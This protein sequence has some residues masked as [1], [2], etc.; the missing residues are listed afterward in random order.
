MSSKDNGARSVTPL[1]N[2]YLHFSGKRLLGGNGKELP[3]SVQL[4]PSDRTMQAKQISYILV[5][6]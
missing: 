1:Y 2:T 3:L 5:F 6:L 4:I